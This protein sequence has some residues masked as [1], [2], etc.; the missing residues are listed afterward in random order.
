MNP[1]AL[2]IHCKKTFKGGTAGMKELVTTACRL[3][4]LEKD[5]VLARITNRQGSAPRTAGAWMILPVDGTVHGTIGGGLLEAA[6]IKAARRV[7]QERAGRFLRFDLSHDDV[8]SMD[9]ICG[10]TV[11]VL[12]DCIRATD[13]NR[14][15]FETLRQMINDRKQGLLVTTVKEAGGGAQRIDYCLMAAGE[16]TC[17]NFPLS[18]SALEQVGGAGL[19]RKPMTTAQMENATVIVEVIVYN[20]TVFI[21]GAGHVA[22][23]TARMAAMVGFRVVVMDDRQAFA[24]AQRFPMADEIHVPDNFES[25]LSG[26]CIDAD[27]YIVILTRGHLF[28]KIVLAQALKSPAAYIGMIGSR[29]KRDAIYSALL[30]EGFND[31]DL[32]KVFSPVGLAIG[33]ETPEEIALSI[34][35][36]MV[37]HR[38]HTS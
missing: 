5:F 25:A 2:C 29:R 30:R 20:K 34:V 33:A 17:G 35:A 4:D 23:P 27:S 31:S 1:D 37:R 7:L 36:E 15:F 11:E 6:A 10:G 3:L 14:R 21:F 19:A 22:L 28:D 18:D 16:I 26:L 32:K 9:M 38:A 12:L 24:N 8:A 13:E